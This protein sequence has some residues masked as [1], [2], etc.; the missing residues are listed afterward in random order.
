M[1][2]LTGCLSGVSEL[3]LVQSLNFESILDSALMRWQLPYLFLLQSFGFLMP[4]LSASFISRSPTAEA[5][6]GADGLLS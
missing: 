2:I 6:V 1:K 3:G 5:V 4:S